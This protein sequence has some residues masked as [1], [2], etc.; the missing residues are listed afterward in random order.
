MSK[1]RETREERE[2]SQSTREAY[3][4]RGEETRATGPVDKSYDP[5]EAQRKRDARSVP[6]PKRK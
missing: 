1:A 5:D 4:W 3:A 6:T 2:A